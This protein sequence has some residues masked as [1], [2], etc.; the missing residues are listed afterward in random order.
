MKRCQSSAFYIRIP[1]PSSASNDGLVSP[2]PSTIMPE[3]FVEANRAGGPDR[4]EDVD[5]KEAIDADEEEEGSTGGT[6]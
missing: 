2:S 4:G 1:S 6:K 5:E 3:V